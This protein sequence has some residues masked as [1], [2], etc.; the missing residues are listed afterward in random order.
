MTELIQ[1]KAG[2]GGAARFIA[3]VAQKKTPDAPAGSIAPRG[4]DTP[5][6]TRPAETPDEVGDDRTLYR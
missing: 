3:N 4:T 1:G 2:S 6:T 5:V